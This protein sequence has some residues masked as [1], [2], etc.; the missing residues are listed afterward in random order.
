MEAGAFD[1]QPATGKPF[2]SFGQEYDPQW[3]EK[4]PI[5]R[6]QVSILPRSLELL[7]KVEAALAAV[8]TPED[9]AVDRR[10]VAALSVEITE[11]D[12]TAVE[13]P[14]TRPSPLDVDQVLAEWRWKRSPQRRTGSGEAAFAQP[15]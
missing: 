8:V 15:R 6:E 5:K 12:A 4:Q 2:P 13:G 10:H 3:R 9:E 11:I 1:N 7:R 14:P